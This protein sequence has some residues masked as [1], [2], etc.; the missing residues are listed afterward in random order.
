M[1]SIRECIDES[2]RIVSGLIRE[3]EEISAIA[4]AI[5]ES[6][7]RGGK[8]IV[9]GNGGSAAQAQHLVAE[10]VVRFKTDRAPFPALALTTDTSILT[11]AAND[12]GFPYTFS[13]QLEALAASDDIVLALS[14]SGNSPNVLRA[15]EKAKEL[16]LKTIA[17][18]GKGGGKLKGE[19]DI[20]LIVDSQATDRIQEAHL[21]LLHIIAETIESVFLQE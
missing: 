3:E 16:K 14:T 18:L 21:L 1:A 15:V 5:T 4:R 2:S 12:Y 11:A 20:E 13:R 8:L 7:K 6:L 17:L 10:L 9:F 19:A